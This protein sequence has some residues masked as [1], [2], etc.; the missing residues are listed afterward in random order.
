MKRERGRIELKKE[1][2]V[3]GFKFQGNLVARIARKIPTFIIAVL[4]RFLTGHTTFIVGHTTILCKEIEVGIMHKFRGT[5][6]AVRNSYNFVPKI[7]DSVHG[8][9]LLVHSVEFVQNSSTIFKAV[10]HDFRGDKGHR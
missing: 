3:E 7:E 8:H 2:G 1:R 5:F 9:L 10:W 4:Y 6:V